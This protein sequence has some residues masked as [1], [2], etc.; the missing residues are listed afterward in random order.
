[1][2]DKL[3]KDVTSEIVNEFENNLLF[4][5]PFIDKFKFKSRMYK[6][7]LPLS[8]IEAFNKLDS[9]AHAVYKDVFDDNLKTTIDSLVD[10]GY[11]TESKN[12][13]GESVYSVDREKIIKIIGE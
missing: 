5:N 9:I 4:D 12:D 6:S 1:M 10:K 13:D 7:L 11:L 3:A 8:E 2:N